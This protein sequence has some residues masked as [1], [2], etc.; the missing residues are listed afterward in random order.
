MSLA[1]G[2]SEFTRRTNVEWL[3]DNWF[4]VLVLVLF[5]AVYFSGPGH[6]GNRG[7]GGYGGGERHDGHGK[8][9]C[10]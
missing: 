8:G 3:V 1:F 9:A 7:H 5:V 4:W 10:H 6:G 2:E